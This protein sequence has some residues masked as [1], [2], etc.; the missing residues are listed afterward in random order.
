[1][2][3]RKREGE[4]TEIESAAKISSNVEISEIRVEA[5]SDIPIEKYGFV[6]YYFYIKPS[7]CM[8]SDL[9]TSISFLYMNKIQI[10]FRIS[11]QFP[12]FSQVFP[13]NGI[14][15][16]QGSCSAGTYSP[17]FRTYTIYSISFFQSFYLLLSLIYCI[18]VCLCVGFSLH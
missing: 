2:E 10:N 11:N 6:F 5:S 1:M 8:Y 13:C 4:M 9:S 18:L 7:C 17:L 16:N 3:E 15:S 12:C 14:Y